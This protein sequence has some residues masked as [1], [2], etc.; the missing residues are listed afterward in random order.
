MG[1]RF[2]PYLTFWVVALV[3]LAADLWT[4]GLVGRQKGIRKVGKKFEG[5]DKKKDWNL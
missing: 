5:G 4:K 1:S 3:G 2:R